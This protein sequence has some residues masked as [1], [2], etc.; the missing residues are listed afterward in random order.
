MRK[1]HRDHVRR[2]PR[3]ALIGQRKKHLCN[4]RLNISIFRTL[5]YAVNKRKILVLILFYTKF[6]FTDQPELKQ[7]MIIARKNTLH[8][9]QGELI[10]SSWE[11]SERFDFL[12]SSSV[13]AHLSA[14]SDD[15]ASSY[16]PI[17]YL[18]D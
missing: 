10:G 3:Y 8:V 9:V 13:R 4:A 18:D 16:N 7:E 14:S 1:Y 6:R 15:Y 11:L 12:K 17:K 2:A 5:G